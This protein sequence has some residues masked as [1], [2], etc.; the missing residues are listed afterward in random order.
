MNNQSINA[1]EIPYAAGVSN[2]TPIESKLWVQVKT[3][4]HKRDAVAYARENGFRV[5]DVEKR[6][7]RFEYAWVINLG[8]S[9]LLGE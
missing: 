4:F 9:R 2:R 3:F 7:G 1:V 6:F 5:C 8:G